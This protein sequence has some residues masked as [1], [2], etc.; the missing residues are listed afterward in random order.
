[1]EKNI[2]KFLISN[3]PNQKFKTK[4]VLQEI[5]FA[6]S[7]CCVGIIIFHYF[8]QSNGKFKFFYLTA[9]NSSWGYMFVT[10]FF[11]MSGTVLYYNY[12]KINSFKIFYFKR[13]K[14][15]FPS[16]YTCYFYFFLKN[17]FSKHKVFYNGHWSRLILS[18]FGMDG[19]LGYRF[20]NYYLIGEWFLGAIIFLYFL[21]PI[22]S[23][24]MNKNI[25]LI[26]FICC[27]G[28]F[29]MFQ[30]EYFIISKT[31]NIITCINSFYFGMLIAKGYKFF[32]KKKIFFISFSL[33]I[34]FYLV[35]IKSFI[36]ILQIQGFCL[37]ILLIN[38]GFYIMRTKYKFLFIEI[39]KLSYNIFLFQRKIILD[40]LGVWNP[41]EWYFHILLLL[42]TVL[43]IIICAKVLYIV[44]KT[45]ID[46]KIFEKIESNFLNN[47]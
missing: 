45:I 15:I 28:Y 12:P 20:K 22:L 41:Y 7:C 5:V 25:L 4:K 23:W 27:F 46:S 1:M 2:Y 19:Y 13:W 24:L 16:Y 40:I 6:R 11:S 34:F 17:V 10:S 38:F 3:K 29:L 14:A 44:V 47:N 32:L 33:F 39:S 26:N 9:A 8:G 37:Y 21:Y 36:I 30:T 43:L 35:K 31:K 42:I 18:L